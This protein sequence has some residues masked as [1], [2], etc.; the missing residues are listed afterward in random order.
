MKKTN[1]DY[2]AIAI[3]LGHLDNK[4]IQQIQELKLDGRTVLGYIK[5]CKNEKWKKPA[6]EWINEIYEKR[7]KF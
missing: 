7:K 1:E 5:S 4:T 3:R 2:M 6:K